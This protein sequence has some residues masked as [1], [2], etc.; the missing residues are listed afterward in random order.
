MNSTIILKINNYS[1]I[2]IT[3]KKKIY[4]N[5]IKNILLKENFLNESQ[6]FYINDKNSEFIR[7]NDNMILNINI[8]N[9]NDMKKQFKL[10]NKTKKIST[11]FIFM[12]LTFVPIFLILI[13]ESKL[14]NEILAW[15]LAI[16]G[17]LFFTISTINQES[18]KHIEETNLQLIKNNDMKSMFIANMSHEL[19]TP[20][21]NIIGLCEIIKENIDI[22]EIY[23]IEDMGNR[24]YTIVNNI[25]FYSQAN[26][27]KIAL[28]N[29]NFEFLE[30]IKNVYN[31]IK[32]RLNNK[33]IKFY[34]N[35][36]EFFEFF[37]NI[38]ICA[39]IDKIS[40]ILINLL[41]NSIKFSKT[42]SK[43]ELFY[44]YE[45]I[46]DN[47]IKFLF[48]I[49][50]YGK[51]IEDNKISKIFLPFYQGDFS[52]TR[53]Y[54][55]TGLGLAIC[56]QLVH[57]MNGNMKV[58]SFP[59]VETCFEFTIIVDKKKELEDNYEDMS[60]IVEI[61]EEKTNNKEILENNLT[62]LKDCRIMVKDD[63]LFKLT[64]LM[65]KKYNNINIVQEDINIDL[66]I[67]KQNGYNPDTSNKN[68]YYLNIP[69]KKDIFYKN[70]LERLQRLQTI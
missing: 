33:N 11:I 62:L 55:G 4:K 1:L 35:D 48:K 27:D 19:K 61:D 41:I 67:I 42:N 70:I 22:K 38:V 10:Y 50:D 40:R 49:L 3:K 46:K 36:K 23:T 63:I 52:S 43:I 8:V 65:V 68:I 47:K 37:E 9:Q 66:Y 7:I 60:T 30:L 5:D 25:L 13:F 26:Y 29:L 51:G 56:N 69:F 32:L 59:N 18:N 6:D 44:F 39:D 2:Y 21:T 34:V 53:K 57:L 28:N 17:F 31:T 54:S 15:F 12:S 64:S 14:V 24:L 16:F 58:Y 45:E 20:I